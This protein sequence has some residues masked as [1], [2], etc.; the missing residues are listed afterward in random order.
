MKLRIGFLVKLNETLLETAGPAIERMASRFNESLTGATQEPIRTD[1]VIS[2]KYRAFPL[3]HEQSI[4]PQRERPQRTDGSG[5]THGDQAKRQIEIRNM[6]QMTGVVD[7]L[8][9]RLQGHTG[10]IGWKYGESFSCR[11]L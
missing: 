8:M 11:H 4:P 7:D 1:I 5:K 9:Q 3:K 2:G 6:E 10:E